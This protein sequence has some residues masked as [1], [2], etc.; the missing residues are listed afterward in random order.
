MK[1]I[2]VVA[3]SV[4]EA[5]AEALQELNADRDDVQIEILDEGNKGFLGIL[6]SKQ[7]KV[8]VE[9]IE[10]PEANKLEAALEFTRELLSKMG[11]S[12]EVQGEEDSESIK[13]QID[14]DDLGILIGRR[15]QT[16]D[17]LQYIVSLAVNRQTE[18]EWNRIQI[19]VGDYRVRR[20]ESL[21]SLASRAASKVE[22]SGRRLALDA[23]NAAERR[24]IH[25]ALQDFPGV[26][27]RSE[28]QDPYRRVVI[29]PS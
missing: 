6:G 14:G 20:E 11:I 22:K 25:Q 21:R 10:K 1:S 8:R 13:L 15:G 12:A 16:L 5:I 19:D 4:D 23:M 9:L 26:E 2:E 29:L 18:G 27:T 7:A 17:S 24:I 28:G 3:R